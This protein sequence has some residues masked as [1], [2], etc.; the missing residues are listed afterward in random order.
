MYKQAW[1]QDKLTQQNDKKK[2]A[3]GQKAPTK[4]STD[5]L[6]AG[7]E[8]KGTKGASKKTGKKRED[9][10]DLEVVID[11]LRNELEWRDEEMLELR[12]E[13]NGLRQ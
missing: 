8:E 9:Q 5:D 11:D 12:N 13:V 6:G 7:G 1:L 3:R 10:Q 4:S 2:K